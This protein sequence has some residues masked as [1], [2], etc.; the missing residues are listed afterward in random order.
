MV[1][2][3]SAQSPMIEAVGGSSVLE[4]EPIEVARAVLLAA[5]NHGPI[6]FYLDG[7]GRPYMREAGIR[8]ADELPALWLVGTYNKSAGT[9]RI[10]EDLQM[11]LVEVRAAHG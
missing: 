9:V 3:M 10:M 1:R 11:R 2:W 8:Y 7:N 6:E 4:R 5:E